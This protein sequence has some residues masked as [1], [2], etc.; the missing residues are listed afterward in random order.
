LLADLENRQKIYENS[1]QES[2]ENSA[3]DN[4]KILA[5]LKSEIES[6]QSQSEK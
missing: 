3:A 2:Q 1:I 5:K 6:K 4:S